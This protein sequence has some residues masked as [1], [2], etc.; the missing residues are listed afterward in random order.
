MEQQESVDQKIETE[1]K[2]FFAKEKFT[3]EKFKETEVLSW[4]KSKKKKNTHLAMFTKR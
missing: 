3:A 1:I 4:W 2:A